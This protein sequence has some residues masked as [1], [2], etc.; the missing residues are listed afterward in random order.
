MSHGDKGVGAS[1]AFQLS[2]KIYSCHIKQ[3]IQY[4]EKNNTDTVLKTWMT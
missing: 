1:V 2:N 4:E 3:I